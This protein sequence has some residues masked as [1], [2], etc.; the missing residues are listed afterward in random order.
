[1]KK[2]IIIRRTELEVK[3]KK[4]F[5]NGKAAGKYEVTGEIMKSLDESGN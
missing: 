2:D 1:M 5:K 4:K 3:T